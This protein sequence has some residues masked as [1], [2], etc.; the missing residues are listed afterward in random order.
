M[1]GIPGQGHGSEDLSLSESASGRPTH[2]VRAAL[3]AARKAEV[4]QLETILKA[5]AE[6]RQ[7]QEQKLEQK[8]AK[9]E[10]ACRKLRPLTA[11]DTNVSRACIVWENHKAD[12][13]V[14]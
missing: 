4:E 8:I 12:P 10:E 11:L 14:T 1:Q 6:V 13:A 5:V 7:V 3:L 9:A 2:A